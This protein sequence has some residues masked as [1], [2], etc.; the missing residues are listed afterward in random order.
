MYVSKKR[1]T[2]RCEPLLTIVG[3]TDSGEM[4]VLGVMAAPNE[5]FESWSAALQRLRRRG[6][7]IGKLR[8]AVSD[9]CPNITKALE[10]EFRELPRQRCTV[11]KTRNVVQNA[12]PAVKT[13]AAK[14]ATAIWD[15]PNK[16]EARHRAAAF[17]ATWRP[18]HP[19]LANI[20]RDDFDINAAPSMLALDT[21]VLQ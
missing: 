16:S 13:A 18:E 15:A 12:A 10:V 8:M 6:L 17:E 3:I 9:S 7:D 5:S 4:H 21:S 1:V 19:R 2:T 14:E 11:H 20:I